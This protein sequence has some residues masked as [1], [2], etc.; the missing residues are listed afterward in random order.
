MRLGREIDEVKVTGD[1]GALM[2]LVVIMVAV[3]SQ[4]GGLVLNEVVCLVGPRMVDIL[5]FSPP[6]DWNPR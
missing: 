5:T 2:A 4:G 1:S 6:S 3:F